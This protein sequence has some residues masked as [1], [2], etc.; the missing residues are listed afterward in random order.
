[1]IISSPS[2]KNRGAFGTTINSF[3]VTVSKVETFVCTSLVCASNCNFHRVKASGVVK[4]NDTFPSASVRNCGKKKAV[5]CR[6]L[7]ILT[8]EKS[9][10]EAD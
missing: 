1:M 9:V 3:C 8:V 2:R 7:R 10:F 5:S 6:F 4:L